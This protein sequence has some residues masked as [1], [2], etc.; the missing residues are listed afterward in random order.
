MFPEAHEGYKMVIENPRGLYTE[1]SLSK[2][3]YICFKDKQY[4]EALPYFQQLQEMAETPANK[5][6]GRLGAMRCAFYLGRFDL[7]LE[8]SNKVLAT[9]KLSPQQASEAKQIKARSLFETGRLD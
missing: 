9:E 3:A 5:T 1:V 8:E 7:A 4:E 2:A 6:A